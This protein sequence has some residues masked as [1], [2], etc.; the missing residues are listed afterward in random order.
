MSERY[1]VVVLG[2]GAMGSASAYHLARRGRRVLG[3]DAF[4]RGHTQGSSHGRSRIIREAYHESPE[5]VPL[6][7]RAYALW[8][9]LEGESGRALLRITGGVN[10]GDPASAEVT[11]VVA[12]A[13]RHGLPYEVLTPEETAGR[14][15]GIRLGDGHVAVYQPTTGLLDP[16]ACV[17][18]HLDGAARA[19]A[20]L[21]HAEP[22]RRW[23]PDGAGVRVETDTGTYTA[24]RLVLTAGPWA[25]DLLTLVRPLLTVWRVVNVHFEPARPDLFAVERCP[26]IG[27]TVPEGHY[28]GV[29]AL[30]GQGFKFGRHDTGE[31]C[32]PQTVR[33]TVDPE[34]VEALRTI[35]DRYLP[36]AAGDVKWTLTCLYTN[37]PDRHFIL[38]RHPEHPQVV[39]ACGFSG[40]GFKFSSVIGEIL[41][42]LAVEGRTGHPIGFL[43][44]ERFVPT[45]GGAPAA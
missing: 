26:V 35:L 43:S 36:G 40:H 20:D 6:V 45:A 37:S 10:A 41:A 30:P 9:D 8:R 25:G 27:L 22:V 21:R 19:G 39:Y 24:D 14:F 5:Y 17:G 31:V 44:R 1:D 38:D 28:Y 29:P 7:Q 11:G 42:D 12:S 33:R 18:A 13:R 34:E 2:L 23:A 3:L 16:E 4:P 32:T 15:P